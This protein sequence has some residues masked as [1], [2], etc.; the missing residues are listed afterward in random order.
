MKEAR[1][2]DRERTRLSKG[3]SGFCVLSES[4]EVP[5]EIKGGSGV[6]GSVVGVNSPHGHP[7]GVIL[8]CITDGTTICFFRLEK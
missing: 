8:V 4:T 2:P 3:G 1:L 7:A 5:L 6:G